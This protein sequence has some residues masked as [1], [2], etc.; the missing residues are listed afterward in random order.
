MYP[1]IPALSKEVPSGGMTLCGHYV[2]SATKI[3]VSVS[4]TWVHLHVC[5]CTSHNAPIIHVPVNC[6][7]TTNNFKC[8]TLLHICNKFNSSCSDGWAS[9]LGHND[10]DSTITLGYSWLLGTADG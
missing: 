10:N 4:H 2:P 6:S 8:I 3:M 9:S 7:K 5:T 1:P